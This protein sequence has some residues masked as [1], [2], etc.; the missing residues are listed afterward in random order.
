MPRYLHRLAWS[1][2]VLFVVTIAG[3]CA[4]TVERL[5]ASER[6]TCVAKGGYESRSAFGFPICQFRYRDGGK[7]CSDKTNC[8]GQCRLSVDGSEQVPIPHPGEKATGLCEAEQYSPGCFV[9]IEG[10]KVTA[11]GA[12]CEE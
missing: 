8:Q 2:A 9:T 4:S 7:S 6:R 10:G 11:E 3:S 1:T 5:G 12:V